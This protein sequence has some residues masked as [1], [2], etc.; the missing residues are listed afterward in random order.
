MLTTDL[1]DFKDALTQAKDAGGKLNVL[2]GN[3]FSVGAHDKFRYGSLFEQAKK[4]DL[5][6]RIEALFDRYGTTNF[7]TVLRHLDEGQWLARHYGLYRR[8]HQPDMG[9]DYEV[10]KEAL[11]EAM[12]AVHPDKRSKIADDMLT[13]AVLFLKKFDSVFTTCYDLL[14]YWVMLWSPDKRSIPFQDGFRPRMGDESDSLVFL[15]QV[16]PQKRFVHFL[17]GALHLTTRNGEVHKRTWRDSDLDAPI[18]EQVREALEERQY[19]L[20]V[21]EGNY[22]N[23][24]ERIESSSY[25]SWVFRRFEEIDGHLFTYGT[26]LSDEDEHIQDAIV[27]NT[28]LTSLLI[29]VYGDMNSDEN[30]RLVATSSVLRRRRAELNTRLPKKKGATLDVSFYNSATAPVWDI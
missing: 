19:P 11:I 3:G 8:D 10:L 30:R 25:L 7:E 21:S 17:H 22:Q 6:N 2:L 18:V 23:K 16:D 15:G 5:P 12:G 9:E 28:K 13:S 27:R 14:L 26:A 29:G 4:S 20:V 24:L 1:I